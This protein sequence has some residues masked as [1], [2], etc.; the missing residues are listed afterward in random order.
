MNSIERIQMIKAME[1]IARQLND[2]EILME[3]LQDGVA[4]GDIKYGDV[5]V[6]VED[7]CNLESY[8]DDRTFADLM[9]SFLWIM[10]LAWRSGGLYCDGV[11]SLQ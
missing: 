4:D 7:A 3:W 1:F 9:D 10:K 6:H 11:S 2:E 8:L 5:A